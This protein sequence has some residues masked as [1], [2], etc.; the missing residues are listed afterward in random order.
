MEM[1]DG[2]HYTL[3]GMPHS[4]GYLDRSS[5]DDPAD[6]R[7]LPLRTY[8]GTTP[9]RRKAKVRASLSARRGRKHRPRGL[10]K[11]ALLHLGLLLAFGLVDG[12]VAQQQPGQL[13]SPYQVPHVNIVPQTP[14]AQ[15]P[16][17][18]KITPLSPD[19]VRMYPQ[20]E[21]PRSRS[22]QRIER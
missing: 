18:N 1:R 8:F 2:G 14:A 13:Q 9:T 17:S 22:Q 5:L 20:Y 7:G 11:G 3:A 16:K 15:V 10:I 21:Q 4:P 19:P 12:A 6:N